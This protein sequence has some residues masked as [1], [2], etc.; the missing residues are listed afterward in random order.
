MFVRQVFTVAA[1]VPWTTHG[2]SIAA[3][4]PAAAVEAARGSVLGA[5]AVASHTAFFVIAAWIY[6]RGEKLIFT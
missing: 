4:L 3:L 6:L 5:V 2:I 1:A